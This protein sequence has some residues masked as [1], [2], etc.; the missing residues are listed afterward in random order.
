MS[1]QSQK[2]PSRNTN[3]PA[4][5][6]QRPAKQDYASRAASTLDAIK[7]RI[8][9]GEWPLITES[10]LKKTGS[11]VLHPNQYHNHTVWPWTTGMEMHARSRLQ[12]FEECDLL[13]SS[14]L[15]QDSSSNL[16]A[17]Y[18]WVNPVT[19]KGDGAFPFRTG[20]SSIRIAVTDILSNMQRENISSR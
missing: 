5:R 16:L 6:Q 17:F 9:K 8:W 4:Q 20:I 15:K 2:T 3:R 19:E 12:Q 7:D 1:L 18:E 11:W 13:M 14:L 10:E